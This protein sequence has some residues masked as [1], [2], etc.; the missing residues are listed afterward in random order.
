MNHIHLL[1]KMG[2]NTKIKSKRSSLSQVLKTIKGMDLVS[3]D[4][5]SSAALIYCWDLL[6]KVIVRSL[7]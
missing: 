5:R 6:L 1:N 4:L 7:V 3:S 2:A